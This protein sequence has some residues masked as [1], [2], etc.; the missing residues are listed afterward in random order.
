MSDTIT[1]TEQTPTAAEM[2]DLRNR[3]AR[4]EK[5]AAAAEE[6][7]AALEGEKEE[8]DKQEAARTIDAAIRAEAKVLGWTRDLDHAAKLVERRG[9]R[10]DDTGKVVGVRKA[11]ENLVEDHPELAALH[12]DGAPPAPRGGT[13]SPARRP[14]APRSGGEQVNHLGFPADSVEAAMTERVL[15]FFM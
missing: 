12:M 3:L 5:R 4:A 11:L 1:T 7:T 10:I 2:N 15:P 14:S 6:R 8:R 9:V 13:P